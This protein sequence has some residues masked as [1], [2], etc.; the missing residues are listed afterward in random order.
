M[1][2]RLHTLA[3][4][5]IVAVAVGWVLVVVLDGGLDVGR[6]GNRD[7]ALG[8]LLAVVGSSVAAVL[9]LL[10]RPSRPTRVAGV[11]IGAMAGFVAWSALSITWA[12]G[13]DLAWVS[14]NRSVA[15][16]AALLIGF[17]LAR[18]LPNPVATFA[19]VLAAAAGV[20][21]AGALLSRILPGLLA[22]AVE[23][24]RLAWGIGA[25]N[26]LA[27]VA[28]MVIPGAA[29][30]ASSR[31]RGVR[32]VAL[33][34]MSC[35][36]LVVA[37][38]QSR[39][40]LISLGLMVVLVVMLQPHRART[41]AAL[42]AAI[43]SVI[44]AAVFA[45]TTP[46]LTREPVLLPGGDRIVTG[47]VL[48]LLTAA[49]IVSTTVF[50]TALEGVMA[51]V[52]HALFATGVR[53]RAIVL[54]GVVVAVAG[55]VAVGVRERSGD[56]GADRLVSLD[57][58]NRAEWWRQAWEGTKDAPIRGHGAGSFPHV[59]LKER[60]ED[61]DALQVRDP[62]QIV[63][64]TLAELGIVGLALAALGVG[65]TAVAA[66]RLGTASAPAASVVA[67]FL[68]HSQLDYTWS[69]AA[70]AMA[71]LAASG[72]IIG[73]AR[74]QPA[75][76]NASQRR[77]VIVAVGVPVIAAA[78]VSA[79]VVWSGLGLVRESIDLGDRGVLA[80]LSGDAAGARRE[81][82]RSLEVARDAT[83]R[84]PL[85]VQGLLQEARAL[86][87][88]DDPA[89]AARAAGRAVDRQPRSAI[90]W[91][92]RVATTTGD[93]QQAAVA[94]LLRLSPSWN[95]SRFGCQPGW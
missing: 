70:T 57:S 41:M 51:R 76:R 68:V 69:I 88:L 62:H 22:P 79:F 14:T 33:A 77:I 5:L 39:T 34:G 59:L 32:P 28:V 40:G 90:A 30:A 84:N 49:A 10:L 16:L 35:A 27:L 52:D 23:R 61:I 63:L 3:W 83:S 9:A 47:L 1:G 73:A 81:W 71:A 91:S 93:V 72:V 74:P 86:T 45:Y 78:C 7:G 48:G 53:R 29:L 94:E 46:A 65:A 82:T 60:T 42:A 80:G 38:T 19:T 12:A 6:P 92:C 15:A 20:V 17:G 66:R 11:A 25:P 18:T 36:L 95:V 37:M 21:V 8:L 89:G 56:G 55:I 85:S 75:V 2:G 54:V 24:P 43:L 31:R 64:G 50:A 87:A 26:A 67:V 44:P 4:A 58:N 13:P